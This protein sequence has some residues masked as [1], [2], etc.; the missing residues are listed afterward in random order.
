MS[1]HD[2]QASQLE[3]RDPTHR[4]VAPKVELAD[5]GLRHELRAT[6]VVWRREIIRFT[7]DRARIVA[8]LLQPLLFLFVMGT[9]LGSVVS[10]S[11]D[12][13]F[14]TFLF[15]GVLAMSVLFMAVFAGISLVWDREFGFLREMLVAPIS[16]AA[17]IIGKCLGGATSATL[18]ACIVLALAPLAGVPYSVSL[19]VILLI[20]LFLGSMMLTSL[21]V[22]LSARIKTIQAAM[23]MTQMLIMPMMFLSGALFPLANLPTWLSVLTKLNPLTYAVQPMRAAVFD[24]IDVSA[25][26]RAQL[27][28]PITWWGWEVPEYV[29]LGV[30]AV[31]TV[32]LIG[33]AVSLFD[34]SD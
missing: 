12:V 28:P 30:V 20:C 10:T 34:R 29:Q 26:T 11:D 14:K 18:Q 21:G 8:M 27:D 23:P 22:V 2:Q 33:V 25:E 24:H 4:V 17:I 1:L 16:K 3:P 13:D 7:Q 19:I 32:A 9:G 6:S 31:V 5:G 15:P